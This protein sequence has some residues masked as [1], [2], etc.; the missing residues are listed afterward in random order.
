MR[1]R[2]KNKLW[3]LLLK[4]ISL[5]LP[6]RPKSTKEVELK[7]AASIYFKYLQRWKLTYTLL[8][9]LGLVIIFGV[10]GFFVV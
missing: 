8:I 10:I 1:P 6:S 4:M 5:K 7:K 3:K 2:L 9:V